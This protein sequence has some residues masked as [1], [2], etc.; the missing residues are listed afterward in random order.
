MIDLKKVHAETAEKMKKAVDATEHEFGSLR[1]GRASLNMLDL[2]TVEAYGQ[3][4]KL[5]AVATLSAPDAHTIV[6]QPWDKG[7]IHPIEKGIAEAGLGL[8]PSN[9]GKIIR[10]VVPALNEDRRK[11][12]VKVA[13]KMAEDG[14][15]SIR[16]IRRNV[17]DELKK[18]EKDKKISEDEHR[19]ASTDIQKLT[20]KSISDIDARL[21]RKEAEIMEV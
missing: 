6:I 13:H 2:V 9:D 7:L 16:N 21:K 19:E 8:N 15:I 3:R 4:Q 11:E 1:T 5:K 17:N 10:I 18:L 12:L 20:D 14:R